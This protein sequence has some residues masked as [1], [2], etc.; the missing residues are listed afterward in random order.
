MA[1]RKMFNPSDENLTN[2]HTHPKRASSTN[3]TLVQ[4]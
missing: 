3:L 4:I 2:F 1:A